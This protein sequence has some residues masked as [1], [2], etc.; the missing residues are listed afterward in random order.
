MHDIE[1]EQKGHDLE[2][3]KKSHNRCQKTVICTITQIMDIDV[4][5]GNLQM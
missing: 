1:E 3:D 5:H 4:G 2:I